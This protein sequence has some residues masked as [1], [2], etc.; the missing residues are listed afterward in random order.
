MNKCFALCRYTASMF[1]ALQVAEWG[2]IKL[3]DYIG[4]TDPKKGVGAN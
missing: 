2:A 4:V 1:H 3:G